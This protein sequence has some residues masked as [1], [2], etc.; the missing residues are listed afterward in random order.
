MP[1]RII[2]GA[3][4]RRDPAVLEAH[5]KTLANQELPPDLQLQLCHVDDFTEN[6]DECRALLRDYGS[7]VLSGVEQVAV[8]DFDDTHNRT[9]LWTQSAFERVA[10]NK[11]RIFDKAVREGY[12]YV[13][14][15]DTDLILDPMTLWS[16]YHAQKPVVAAVYWTRWQDQPDQPAQPQVWLRHPYQ[17]DGRGTD[18]FT[19]RWELAHRNLVRVWGLGACMLVRTEA[20]QHARYWPLMPELVQA[21]QQE[22]MGMLAGEDRTFSLLCERAHIE[23]WGDAWP[24]IYHVYHPDDAQYAEHYTNEFRLKHK[25]RALYPTY[26]DYVSLSIMPFEDPNY[27]GSTAVRGRLG[28]IK[29]L[30]EL[31]AAVQ[32]MRPGDRRLLPVAF[33]VDYPLSGTGNPSQP[34]TFTPYRGHTRTYELTLIDHKPYDYAPVLRDDHTPV[35][36]AYRDTFRYTQEQIQQFERADRPT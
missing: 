28:A 14:I 18:A 27:T 16:M 32:T 30:P 10:Q 11:Q 19:F 26:G 1:E 36:L 6:V 31:E 5:L 25:Y 24:D 23:M 4:A 7:E 13:W 29:L 20:L 17:L 3:S 2:V 35:G 9:H 8:H 21:A 34:E 12:D 22:G 15:C 33:P